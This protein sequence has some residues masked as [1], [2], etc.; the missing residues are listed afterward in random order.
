MISA[1]DPTDSLPRRFQNLLE[2]MQKQIDAQDDEFVGPRYVDPKK[3]SSDYEHGDHDSYHHDH[4]SYGQH[5][6]YGP[7]HDQ[8]YGS[9]EQYGYE[10]Q[11]K[12]SFKYQGK[13]DDACVQETA[14]SSCERTNENPIKYT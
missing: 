12:S 1:A 4:H 2:D 13:A 14:R 9:H 3:G 5:D 10:P 8:Q 6:Y 11:R 7:D